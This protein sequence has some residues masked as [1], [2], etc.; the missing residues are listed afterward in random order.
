[1]A[2]PKDI[3]LTVITPEKQVL[4]TTTAEVVIPAHDGEIGVLNLRAPL[5]CELGIGQ[6][7]Y[8]AGGQV[9]RLF[10]DGGFAQVLEN[11]VTVLTSRALPADQI[12]PDVLA[13]AQQAVTDQGGYEE[14]VRL[15]RARA[16]QRLS[17]LQRMKRA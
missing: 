8:G 15:A 14:E 7:R 16:Q 10:I 9:Q 1:M 13:A 3:T 2:G 4:S 5:V 12:T 11:S 17:V 6:L